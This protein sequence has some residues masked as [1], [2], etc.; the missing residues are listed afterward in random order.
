MDKFQVLVLRALVIILLHLFYE[1]SELDKSAINLS[2][3]AIDL[4]SKI[5]QELKGYG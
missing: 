3:S 1:N 5:E 2:K 4:A